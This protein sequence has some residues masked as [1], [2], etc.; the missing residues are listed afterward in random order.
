[1]AT[2]NREPKT[3]KSKELFEE[4]S[5]HVACHVCKIAPRKLPIF[6]SMEKG[7]ICSECKGKQ[8]FLSPISYKRD[9]IL[10]K[11]LIRL[12]T[13]CRNKV[14]GCDYVQD[15]KF[16]ESH[17]DE[18]QFRCVHCNFGDCVLKLPPA[19]LKN[20]YKVRHHL[21]IDQMVSCA[22]KPSYHF[23]VKLKASN[24]DEWGPKFLLSPCLIN[25]K[26]PNEIK[27]FFLHEQLHPSKQCFMFFMQMYGKKS[28]AQNYEYTIRLVDGKFGTSS[29]Q[30]E[31]FKSCK[32]IINKS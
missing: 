13:S 6:R 20:H 26:M 30:G 27:T 32:L 11:I 28:E 7:V 9:L 22:I 10:E 17:E 1:M 31:A 29:Y 19:K 23:N 3:I 21:D 12:P 16:I 4:I 25:I 15:S 24:F 18:C 5:D 8:G 14:N 2:A